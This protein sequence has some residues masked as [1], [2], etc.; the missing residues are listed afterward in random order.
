MC[1]FVKTMETI[2]SIQIARSCDPNVIGIRLD[3]NDF[4]GVE[5]I[6]LGVYPGIVRIEEIVGVVGDQPLRGSQPEDLILV[7]VHGGNRGI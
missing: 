2:I 5:K 3:L 7:H 6:N 1:G 4:V